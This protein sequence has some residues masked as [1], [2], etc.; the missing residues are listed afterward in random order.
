MAGVCLAL[1]SLLLAQNLFRDEGVNVFKIAWFGDRVVM[2]AV[3][4]RTPDL[5]AGLADGIQLSHV[6]WSIPF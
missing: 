1:C 3:G 5:A 6:R 4:E 2:A